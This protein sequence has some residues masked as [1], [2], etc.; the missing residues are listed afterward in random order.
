MKVNAFKDKDMIF[1]PC[2]MDG[3]F[4]QS[5]VSIYFYLANPDELVNLRNEDQKSYYE[6]VEPFGRFISATEEELKELGH[7]EEKEIEVEK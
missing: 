2:K 6:F 5:L 3:H 1:T 4:W 7:I